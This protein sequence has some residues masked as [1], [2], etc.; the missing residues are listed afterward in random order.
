M[1]LMIRVALGLTLLAGLPASAQMTTGTDSK[2]PKIRSWET[3]VMCTVMANTD[4]GNVTTPKGT[5][6]LGFD[7]GGGNGASG[8]DQGGGVGTDPGVGGGG[9]GT[10]TCSNSSNDSLKNCYPSPTGPTGL[11][12]GHGAGATGTRGTPI[13]SCQH[14]YQQAEALCHN[15]ASCISAASSAEKDCL[16][17]S[18]PSGT[19]TPKL[20]GG[21]GGQ[22]NPNTLMVERAS[23]TVKKQR[24]D[25]LHTGNTAYCNTTVKRSMPS[26]YAACVE[27]T[28]ESYDTCML[29]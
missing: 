17:R 7:D 3:V 26:L 10:S 8:I 9:T 25:K 12:K 13:L 2:P 16:S 27:K 15:A 21:T 28:K 24:C 29:P 20:P 14:L 5:C 23:S 1:P 18:N 4:I 22:K 11:G 19:S 6:D